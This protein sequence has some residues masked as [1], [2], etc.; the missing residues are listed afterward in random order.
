MNT[1]TQQ[2][3]TPRVAVSSAL[4]TRAEVRQVAYVGLTNWAM[5]IAQEVDRAVVPASQLQSKTLFEMASVRAANALGAPL[6]SLEVREAVGRVVWVA[7]E[8]AAYPRDPLM[9][10]V[11]FYLS[12]RYERAYCNY[13]R[14]VVRYYPSNECWWARARKLC[15]K[16]MTALG[17]VT[18]RLTRTELA[19]LVLKLQVPL[20]WP[21]GKP[22]RQRRI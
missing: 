10:L 16:V 13:V 3:L 11:M 5:A 19:Y 2:V 15:D 21:T 1:Q 18:N 8:K 7:C 14:H 4:L 12:R 20:A 22:E 6:G 17:E 9:P